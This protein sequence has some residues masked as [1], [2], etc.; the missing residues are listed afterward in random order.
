MKITAPLVFLFCS[1]FYCQ[2]FA[3][4]QL[5]EE[6]FQ[7]F[8]TTRL[9][10]FEQIAIDWKMEG[11]LQADLNEGLN[12]LLENKP[13]LAEV[14]LTTVIKKNSAIWQAYYYRAAARKQLRKFSPAEGDMRRALKLRGNFYEGFVELAKILHLSLR[15]AESEH[16][17]DKAIRIDASSGAAYQVKGD[18]SMSWGETTKAID[19]YMQ[20]LAVDSLF[21]DARIKLALLDIVI[22]KKKDT[23]LKRLNT[24][25][26]YDSL[27]HDA[28]LFRGILNYEKDKKQTLA[29]LSNLIRISPNN[30]VGIYY[31]GLVS[32]ELRDYAAAFRDFQK[33]IK[34]T[35][36]SEN[37]FVG[38]QTSLDK[39]IDMQNVG[40]YLLTR[41]Y[42]LSDDDAGIIKEAYCHIIT[43]RYSETHE[44]IDRI[45]NYKREPGAVYLKA[46]AF[47]H[48]GIHAL[49]LDYY[50][51]ALRLDDQIADAH[52]KRGIYEQELKQ[53]DKSV[54]DF[55]AVLKLYPYDFRINWI[56]GL[57]F[58]HMKW[59]PQAIA[60]FTIFLKNDS[61]N[62]EALGARGMAYSNSGKPLLAY[63]D[64][65]ASGNIK[66]LN[67]IHMEKLVDSVL[68][69]KD[70]TLALSCLSI[71]TKHVAVFSEGFVQKFRI[72]IARNQWEPIADDLSAALS[73][74]PADL[75]KSKHS[76]LLTVQAMM[77]AR[78]KRR[79]DAMKTFNEAI[80]VDDGNG[81]AYLERGRLFLEMRKSS[82][83]ENDFKKALSLGNEQAKKMLAGL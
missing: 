64:F 77:H 41:V 48:Q 23:A 38:R 9:W 22:N 11:I 67:Y 55:T 61:T 45:F 21:H 66:A 53:W 68:Q 8:S 34:A 69:A 3:Q 25:L 43:G 73:N 54:E 63:V 71:I 29:D 80:K 58:Y 1:I 7:S 83:A 78:D 74:L 16:A 4:T 27:Q 46:V 14:S 60:D 30:W 17:I 76:Y 75:A 12:Y 5:F 40:A 72:H 33:V 31:R 39:K 50:G 51:R 15:K 56:R 6:A 35:A 70:T 82:K 37:N 19:S 13:G 47:E 57:S 59:F 24:V 79:D 32:A 62:K 28:L 52:K 10:D 44:A 26:S 42:G 2:A 49:A 36:T 65:A 20:C 18:I 81:V